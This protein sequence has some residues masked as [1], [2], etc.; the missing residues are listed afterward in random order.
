MQ[1]RFL[2]PALL[3]LALLTLTDGGAGAAEKMHPYDQLL[4]EDR[5]TI[6][7]AYACADRAASDA[8]LFARA[9]RDYWRRE[10]AALW[11]RDRELNV[12]YKAAQGAIQ[13]TDRDC[14][15]VRDAA[16]GPLRID[17]DTCLPWKIAD[18]PT[19]P[20]VA[21]RLKAV[22]AFGAER[23]F[24]EPGSR[25][26]GW[27]F[28]AIARDLLRGEP[29]PPEG[30][31]LYLPEH[32]GDAGFGVLFKRGNAVRWYGPDC[33]SLMP[34]AE[35]REDAR[36]LHGPGEMIRDAFI[37]PESLPE[38]LTLEELRFLRVRYR[39]VDFNLNHGQGG[40]GVM[41]MGGYGYGLGA[42]H[43]ELK[44]GKYRLR[45]TN[46]KEHPQL[47]YAPAKFWVWYSRAK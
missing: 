34:M 22:P 43:F 25:E 18:Y 27:I 2:K 14:G 46:L 37:G 39:E 17:R 38:G 12:A 10:A 3:M 13:V 28:D 11:N 44:P 47:Q 15:L 29:F 32:N 9:M 16:G 41:S 19:L 35:A 20:Q 5:Q 42:E 36:R 21:E 1:P 23:G 26:G 30:R 6:G 4:L 40:V 33:C 7:A 31:P 45:I 24:A 8:E